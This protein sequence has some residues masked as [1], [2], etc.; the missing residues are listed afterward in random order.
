MLVR[1]M[2]PYARIV[3]QPFVQ[4]AMAHIDRDHFCRAAL[5]HAV[6]ESAGRRASV[7]DSLAGHVDLEPIERGVEL[8]ASTTHEPGPEVR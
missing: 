5:K 1:S 6:G 2:D 8:V 3:A 7:E 4:L